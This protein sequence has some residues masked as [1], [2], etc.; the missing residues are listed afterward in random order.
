MLDYKITQDEAGNKRLE[1]S[2]SGKALL[3]ISALNKATAFTT[4]ER[5]EF[6]LLGKLPDRVETLE[7]QVSRVYQQYLS[8]DKLI[9]R[10]R[11]LN[12]LLDYNQILFY[13]LI[14]RYAEE[15]LPVIYTPFVGSNVKLY[16]MRFMQPRGLY[17]SYQNQ[18]NIETILENR[19]NPDIQLIVVTDGEAILG[20]GDQ[21]IGGM[22]IPVA[23]LIVYSLFGGI[24]PNVTLPIVL[25]VGTNNEE[26]LQDPL[27]LGWRHRRIDHAEYEIFMDKFFNALKKK[28]PNAFLHFEDFG[29]YNATYYLKKYQHQMCCFND[30]IQG[31]GIV[32]L[33]AVMAAGRKTKTLLNRQR[34]VVFGAGSAGMG[35]T[36]SIYKALIAN[37]LSESEAR[38][39]FWIVDRAGL[40]TE[41]SPTPTEAQQNFLRSEAEISTWKVKDPTQ[42]SLLEVIQNVKPTILIGTSAKAGAFTQEIIIE[43]AKYI[44][45]PTILPLSNPNE[46]AEATPEDIIR[47][48]KG[49]ALVATG[50]PFSNV[51][52]DGLTYA[53]SQCNNYLAFPGLGL[54]ILATKAT[55]LSDKMLRAA[56][57]ALAIYAAQNCEGLL[58]GILQ[59]EAAS[60]Q[61]AI[62][63]AE[64]AIKEGYATATIDQP[65]E[66]FI[67]ALKWKPEYLPYARIV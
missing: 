61:I 41:F 28:F 7:D 11:Y 1:T 16:N 56:S 42:I 51:E 29:R 22:A 13:E 67:K 33:A 52:Y 19:T 53:I 65:L 44:E 31:T 27:Y 37:S 25:D 17:V 15:M 9:N 55:Q 10:N 57:N 54:G 63:V 39:Q 60:L 6:D 12:R 62:A 32:A 38:Q 34:I 23:K 35:I 43:M 45:H 66:Q 4:K 5:I 8:Y 46:N 14:K 20:I 48:T 30:D 59:V 64:A 21:G 3:S 18:D 2:I 26:I 24:N 36:D 50:S 49:Q 58:P 47:W 40:L